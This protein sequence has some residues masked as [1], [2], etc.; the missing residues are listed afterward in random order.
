MIKK[1]TSQL[2]RYIDHILFRSK[3]LGPENGQLKEKMSLLNKDSLKNGAY[4]GT[5]GQRL[6]SALKVIWHERAQSLLQGHTNNDHRNILFT[7]EENVTADNLFGDS[8]NPQRNNTGQGRV[9]I[10]KTELEHAISKAKNVKA[11]PKLDGIQIE[12]LKILDLF[13]YIR[14]RSKS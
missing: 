8:R 9:D 7:N 1:T 13:N 6:T 5:T 2:L 4:H 14:D 11:P 10:T 12:M 3:R